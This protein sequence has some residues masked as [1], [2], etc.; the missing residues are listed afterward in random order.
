MSVAAAARHRLRAEAVARR[1]CV[2]RTALLAAWLLAAASL[3][4]SPPAWAG[5]PEAAAVPFR[6]RDSDL[7]TALKQ[8]ARQADMQ[9]LY[10]PD[11]VAGRRVRR[12]DSRLAP[13]QALRHLL[14][15]TGLTAVQVNANTFTLRRHD[16]DP[17]PRVRRQAIDA[18]SP[19]E[20]PALYV[21]G[22]H[23]PRASPQGSSPLTLITRDQIESSG[24][25]SLFEL[26]RVQPGMTG[27]HPVDVAS[28]SGLS[29]VP[30]GAAAAV[31]LS[32][33]GPRGTLY[34]VDGR[35]IASYGLVSA[36]LGAL[37]DLN[38][39]PLSLVERVEIMR[40]GASAIYGADAMA[41]VVNIVLRDGHA[42]SEIMLRHGV[43]SRGDAAQQRVS[44][45]SGF[46]AG[47]GDVLLSAD[48]LHRQALPGDRRDWHG[49][50][51]SGDGLPDLRIPLGE[52]VG[53]D[54]VAW[55]YCRAPQLQ[56]DGRCLFDPA[57][58]D[59]LQPQLDS[60][61][62][63]AR[64]R[65]PLGGG[66]ELYASLRLA[67]VRQHLASAPIYGQLYL[68]DTL[69]G[70]SFAPGT[71]AFLELGPVRSRTRARSGDLVVGLQGDLGRWDWTL[72]TA[73]SH[74]R[75]DSLIDGMVSEPALREATEQGRFRPGMAWLEPALR[76]QIS[77][78]LDTGGQVRQQVVSAQLHGPLL[79]LPGGDLQ[80]A[81]GVEA[82]HE[83]LDSRPDSRLEA[84]EVALSDSYR[85]RHLRRDT[86]SL[87]AEFSLPLHRS[88]L[89]D[90]A[91]RLDRSAGYAARLSPRFGLQWQPVSGLTLRGTH[92]Q[93]YRAP[94]LYELRHPPGYP[95]YY[96]QAW[97]PP[98]EDAC[99][100]QIDSH[101]CLVLV[102]TSE[103]AALRPETSRSHTLGL[104]WQAGAGLQ[105]AVDRQRIVRRG[106]IVV[107]D[108]LPDLQAY[109]QTWQLDEN[110]RIYAL[111]IHLANAGLTRLD[112]WSLDADWRS[113]ST[114]WGRFGLRL[115]GYYLE[116][117]WRQAGSASAAVEQAGF[118]Q[119]RRSGLGSLQWQRGDWT[120]TLDLRYVGALHAWRA[121]GECP[122][123]KVAAGRCRTPSHMVAGLDVAYRGLERW[124]LAVHVA[125]LGDRAPVDY[126]ER[127]GGYRIGSDDPF[128]RYFT[129]SATYRF[130]DGS[131]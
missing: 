86:G 98:G 128:G 24:Y 126:R 91:W 10:A 99:R 65:R 56:P 71:Y 37:S 59:S 22:S 95:N 36:E 92:G 48:H 81:V 35:R 9:I 40:G 120:T 16:A 115:S 47:G 39:I 124:V 79:A 60:S 42:G 51:R 82:R 76:E 26:L 66:I 84:G 113:P 123:Y 31:S 104:V 68:P 106:E 114:R 13:E 49:H 11:Q 34:L 69:A 41:G 94:T 45:L 50:D 67:E 116:S 122:A 130:G 29:F 27:H 62:V 100:W 88:L 125:N 3:P 96:E 70:E 20:L 55:P 97:N 101:S 2:S 89:A 17:P 5:T 44:V 25:S 85:R 33:L 52:Y 38:S 108:A 112:A 93:G 4:W 83:A 30:T 75:A 6:I 8:W 74:N 109:P 63:Y 131:P 46:S 77:P 32:S 72:D 107:A 118:E 103:N 18:P 23:I 87:Y 57:R 7:D 117:L 73:W 110:G 111:D 12:L 105:L 19:T 15:G 78:T 129:F 1:P 28:E 64:Y 119:P 53:G 21:T 61:A 14:H 121:G 54:I 90:A 127:D 80:L 58:Y 102:K 43:S